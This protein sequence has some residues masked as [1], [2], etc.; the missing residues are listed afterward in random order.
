VKTE[1]YGK[2]RQVSFRIGP[3]AAQR[4]K[5]H[6]LLF[7]LPASE[8]AKAVLYSDLEVFNEPLD[9]RRRSWKRKRAA[10]ELV[11]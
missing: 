7:N 3:L 6:A 5:E 8:Y 4:L 9:Q 10:E 11:E 2:R 1:K